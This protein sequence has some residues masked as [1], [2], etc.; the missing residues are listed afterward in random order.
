MKKT[1]V[2][3]FYW[4]VLAVAFAS[5][6]ARAETLP[7]LVTGDESIIVTHHHMQTVHGLL[8]YEARAGRLAVRNDESGQVRAYIFFVAYVAKPQPGKQRPLTFLW[9]GGPTA[10]SL[11]VHTEVFGPRRYTQAGMQDNA[12]T[13]L[14]T[15][16]LVFYDPVET[17]FSRPAQVDDTEFLSTLGD[18]AVT[19]EFVRAYRARFAAEDQPL[20]LGGESYGTWRVCGVTEMLAKRGIPVSGAI[21]I[22]GGVPGSL[23]PP[24]FQDAMYVPARTAA[25]FQLHKLSPE[26]M[27]DRQSTMK[28]VAEWTR[29]VYWPSLDRLDKLSPEERESIVQ[30]LALFIG[31]KPEQINHKTLVMTNLEYRKGLF[32][33]DSTKELNTYDMRIAGVEQEQPGRARTLSGYLRHELGYQTDL[34]YTGLEDGYMP[35]PGPD[36]R[37]TGDRWSYNHVEL[38]PQSMARMNAGGGPPLSQP[39]L[40]NAMHLDKQIRVFVAAGRY[41]SLNMCEG[42]QL[43][44]AKLEPDLAR[45]FMHA[46]YEGGHMMYRDQ[47]T[48]LQLVSDIEHFLL[49]Q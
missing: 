18:F 12:E 28:A 41:D 6:S 43:M 30:K 4:L 36:R 3:S 15:S 25:A 13:L 20:F 37:S 38:T 1:A 21:L 34:A 23:M 22:S 47:P 46:C 39:W 26:L 14:A 19:A 11:L 27:R 7:P 44:S 33:G 10:E 48:R 5:F 8:D 29:T 49:G 42:N 2:F 35:R 24:S 16:D 31:V 17:G 40:Q 32:A 45:R 9:N